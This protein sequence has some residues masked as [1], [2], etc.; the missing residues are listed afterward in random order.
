[1]PGLAWQAALKYTG[2]KL[3]LLT[4]REIYDHFEGGIRGG[5]SVVTTRYAE[6][7]HPHLPGYDPSKPIQ[8]IKY[9]DAV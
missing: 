9:F 3:E 8:E 5:P 6:A 7:N 1:M 4:D 2:V